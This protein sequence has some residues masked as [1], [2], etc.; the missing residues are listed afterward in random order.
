LVAQSCEVLAL[1]A[2]AL[3]E[4]E[5]LDALLDASVALDAAVVAELAEAVADVAALLAEPEAALA[6]VVAVAAEAAALPADVAASLALVLDVV[7]EAA[8]AEAL[9]AAAEDDAL[10]ALAL[11]AAA[12]AWYFAEYSEPCT[13]PVVLVAQSIAAAAPVWLSLSNIRAVML[14]PFK[15]AITNLS[16]LESN[17][18]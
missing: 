8:E 16:V 11:L 9:V 10:D 4:P 14:T 3:A 12:C 15:G 2:A 18:E 1:V 13:G 6:C 5:A 17:S 7:A